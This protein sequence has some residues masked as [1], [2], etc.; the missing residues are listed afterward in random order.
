MI[1]SGKDVLGRART[2][3]GK[4]LAFAL[5]V[6]ERMLAAGKDAAGAA[7]ARKHGRAPRVLVLA[8][9]RE[10]ALQ[11]EKEFEASAPALSCLCVYGGAQMGPQR[12]FAC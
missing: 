6:I 3:T 10:L 4:T 11:V 5:P 9:T 8:P 2:G 12:T 7:A 1:T